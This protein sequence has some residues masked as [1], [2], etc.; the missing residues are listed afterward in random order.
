MI[1]FTRPMYLFF[2]LAI[3]LIV[4]F[5]IISISLSKRK[6]IKFANFDAISRVSG[7]DIFSKNLTVLYLHLL[8][9][10]LVV[11]SV[12]GTS[13][14]RQV[15]STD[16]SFVIAVDASRS[17]AATDL[18]P[19]RL[20]VAKKAAEDFLNMMPPKTKI[21]VLSFS[22]ATY[23]ES[24]VTD[25]EYLIKAAIDNINIKDVGGTDFL[26]TFATASNM[27]SDQESKNVILISDG[28][29]NLNQLQTIND[30][31]AKNNIIVYSLGIGTPEG[32]SDAAGGLFT[33]S[34]DTLKIISENSGGRYYN[35]NQLEDF[36]S[37]FNEILSLAK[38]NVIFD[39]SLFLMIG[40]LLLFVIEFILLNTRFRTLP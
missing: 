5:H 33:L 20:D 23:I 25:D 9:V 16:Q 30:Y 34:E 36:Y 40:A 12:S 39:M 38:K 32:G 21:G 11:L 22:G 24:E 28:S 10:L 27:L 8:I 35:V 19:T 14:V 7:V 18:S 4:F 37:S 2:L 17:M 1:I 29:A 26:G 15:E 13:L 31:V 3:P 6:A